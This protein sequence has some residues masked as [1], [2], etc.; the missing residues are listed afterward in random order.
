MTITLTKDG[1]TLEL[2]E[3]LLWPDEFSWAAVAQTTER[4]IDGHLIVDAML[5]NGGR[6]ITLQGDGDSAWITRA[7]LLVLKTWAA[8]P[9]Q[10]FV[11]DL[12][13]QVWDVIFDHGGADETRSMAM[14]PVVGYSD[15]EDG[16]F[17]CSLVLRFI[18]V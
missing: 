8:L 14:S 3:D 17:Y 6:P 11:L 2:P 1:S 15:M 13:G 10:E 9:G 5:R 12:R 16:D 18:E 4:G 7:D